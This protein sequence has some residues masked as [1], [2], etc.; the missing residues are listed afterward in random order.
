MIWN[1][2]KT[3]VENLPELIDFGNSKIITYLSKFKFFIPTSNGLT[4]KKKQ[5]KYSISYCPTIN[6]SL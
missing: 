3:T 2:N 6:I 1:C 5:F 4:K